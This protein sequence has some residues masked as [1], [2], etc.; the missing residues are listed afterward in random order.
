M[1]D[2][3]K[4]YPVSR[5]VDCVQERREGRDA[6][7]TWLLTFKKVCCRCFSSFDNEDTREGGFHADATRRARGDPDGDTR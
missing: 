7:A 2:R 5:I 3:N 1:R 6:P 4:L